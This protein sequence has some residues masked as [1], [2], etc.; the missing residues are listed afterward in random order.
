MDRAVHLRIKARQIFIRYSCGLLGFY[1]ALNANE[2]RLRRIKQ[3]GCKLTLSGTTL[4][5]TLPKKFT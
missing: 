1:A 4:I 3:R 5:I 2:G